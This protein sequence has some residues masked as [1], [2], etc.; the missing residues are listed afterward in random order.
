M[1]IGFYLLLFLLSLV[2]TIIIEYPIRIFFKWIIRD[3]LEN[4]TIENNI[5]PI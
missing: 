5:N 1:T 2:L 4:I 3:K